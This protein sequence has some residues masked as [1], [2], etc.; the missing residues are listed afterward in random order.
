M[1]KRSMAVA[2]LILLLLVV[3]LYFGFRDL[4]S[5]G[6]TPIAA[7]PTVSLANK[8]PSPGVEVP[9]PDGGAPPPWAA[10]TTQ[11][12]STA[13]GT[14]AFSGQAL[15]ADRATAAQRESRELEQMQLEISEMLRDGKQPDP[16][17]IAEMLTS[18]KQ[19]HGAV[20]AGVNLDAVL[21]NLQVAQ[22]IQTLALEVQ[23]EG[24]KPGG[25]DSKQMQAYVAQLTK[26]QAK[27]RM[28]ITVPQKPAAAQ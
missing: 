5:T 20:V 18:L 26:L 7:V 13:P 15:P 24:N 11:P 27:M 25:G 10:G 19:K 9:L 21:N 3:T 23:R 16:K 4:S 1:N 6:S 14:S 8:P 2:A 28:D 22:E 12:P 17:R